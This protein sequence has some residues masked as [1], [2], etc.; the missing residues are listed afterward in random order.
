MKDMYRD[1][2]IFNFKKYFIY[3]VYF[4]HIFVEI[5]MKYLWIMCTCFIILFQWLYIFQKYFTMIRQVF[6]G[7][8]I[9]TDENG[10]LIIK[11]N[12]IIFIED[13]KVFLTYFIYVYY[14]Y[15]Y[16]FINNSSNIGKI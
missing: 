12:I 13:G 14:F 3:F 16:W 5:F 15:S 4:L 8:M 10:E 6:I 2:K 1:R 11:K 7:P 9:H